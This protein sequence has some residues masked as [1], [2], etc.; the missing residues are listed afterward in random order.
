MYITPSAHRIFSKVGEIINGVEKLI[1]DE[2][3]HI[4]FVRPKF[5]IGSSGTVWASETVNLRYIYPTCL[6]YEATRMTILLHSDLPM[7][8]SMAQYSCTMTCA[9]LRIWNV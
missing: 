7:L 3:N 5:Y 1:T 8:N 6:K 9:N 2:D 4:V